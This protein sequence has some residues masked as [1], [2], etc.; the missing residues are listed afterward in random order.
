[1]LFFDRYASWCPGNLQNDTTGETGDDV[2]RNTSTGASSRLQEIYARSESSSQ[3]K[4]ICVVALL[5]NTLR[6]IFKLSRPSFV[7]T[8]RQK[9]VLYILERIFVYIGKD[10]KIF[11]N[12]SFSSRVV[13]QPFLTKFKNIF[14]KLRTQ[15]DQKQQ[16]KLKKSLVYKMSLDRRRWETHNSFSPLERVVWM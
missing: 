9:F 2:Q 13:F 11:W 14:H 16:K 3:K 10:W 6:A 12:N 15:I 4:F 1:M 7:Q 5:E 8:L